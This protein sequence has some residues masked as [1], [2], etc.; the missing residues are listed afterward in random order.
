MVAYKKR[1]RGDYGLNE[2]A[3]KKVYI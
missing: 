2:L 1:A 3:A